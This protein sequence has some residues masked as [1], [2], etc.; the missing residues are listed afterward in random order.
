LKRL[1]AANLTNYRTFS[2]HIITMHSPPPL[3]MQHL[4]SS[5]ETNLHFSWSQKQD[6]ELR[7]RRDLR[8]SGFTSVA[9]ISR[10]GTSSS[11]VAQLSLLV[12]ILTFTILH[13]LLVSVMAFMQPTLPFKHLYNLFITYTPM[14]MKQIYT[15]TE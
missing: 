13:D 7:S 2:I 14:S 8:K 10:R 4:P 15:N 1:I 12:C 9:F 3:H 5:G 11:A 6:L